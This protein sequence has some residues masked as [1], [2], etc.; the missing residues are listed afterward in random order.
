MPPMMSQPSRLA[1][2][3]LAIREA[4]DPIL[5]KGDESQVDDIAH[6]VPQFEERTEG[7][8]TRVAHIHVRADQ[9][10]AL[11]DLPEDRLASATLDIL[12]RERRLAFGPDLDPFDEGAGLVVARF[13]DGQGGV[14]MDVRID[15]RRGEEPSLAF[16]DH[17][18]GTRLQLAD[19]PDRG[20]PVS[21]DE[22]IH[23]RDAPHAGG[24]DPDLAD[25]QTHPAPRRSADRRR[26]SP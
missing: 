1:H 20:D 23:R 9:S 13:A 8:E 18:S 21:G 14:Q 2:Q 22:E 7:D 6:L 11:G 16:E 25:E 19:R 24:M 15:K 26:S 17:V 12:K 10:R 4:Q 3:L 5:W